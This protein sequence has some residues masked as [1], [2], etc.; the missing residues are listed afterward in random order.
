MNRRRSK[1][2]SIVAHL[3][4]PVVV[5]GAGCQR[6]TYSPAFPP[7]LLGSEYQ[8]PES[9]QQVR[10]ERAVVAV[11]GM[12]LAVS[13]VYVDLF[14]CRGDSSDSNLYLQG[15]AEDIGFWLSASERPTLFIQVKKSDGRTVELMRYRA[16]RPPVFGPTHVLYRRPPSHRVSDTCFVQVVMLRTIQQLSPGEYAIRLTTAWAEDELLTKWGEPID[17]EWHTVFADWATTRHFE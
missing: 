8:V 10:L 16:P 7:P 2:V 14:V 6:E 3:I 13:G 9:L 12:R 5:V 15:K 4:L 11:A 1:T 17:H